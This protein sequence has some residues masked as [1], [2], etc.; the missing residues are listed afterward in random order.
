MLLIATRIFQLFSAPRPLC[1][2]LTGLLLLTTLPLRAEVLPYKDTNLPFTT[3]V[4]DLV[5]RMTLEEKAQQMQIKMAANSRLGIPAWDWWNEAIH[6]IARGG[7]ATMFPQAIGLGAT[8]DPP[9]L[10]LVGEAIGDEARAKF[11]P[12]GARYRGLTM[13]APA[14]NLVRDP[15]WGRA[16]ETYGE[17]PC[18]TTRLA[19]EFCKGLQGDD[20]KYLK[21]VATP[22]H[23]AL[24]SQETGRTSTSFE[25]SETTLRDYYLPAFYACFT[26]A[27]ATS[28]M[29]AH[30]GINKVP[31]TA[32]RWLLTDLLRG[33]WKFEGAVVTDWT[34]IL[35]L[36]QGHHLFKTPEESA[37]GAINAGIDVLSQEPSCEQS[38]LRAV[39]TGLLT[40]EVLDQAVTRN[41]LLRFRLGIFDPPELVAFA[42][43]PASVVGSPAHLNLA[44]QAARESIVLLQNDPALPGYG[45]ERILPLNLRQVRSVALLGPYANVAQLGNYNGDPAAPPITPLAGIRQAF[46]DRIRIRTANWNDE[47]QSLKAAQACDVVLVVLGLNEHLEAE[48][49]DKPNLELPVKQRDF[50][51]RLMEVNPITVV[52]VEG[53]SPV[54]L[55]WI[56]EHVPAVLMLWYP[57]EQG[58]SALAEVLLGQTN[59]SGRLPMTFYRSSSDLPPLD[60]YEISKGR[61]YMYHEKPVP[62]V[63]G[64]GLSYTT[65]EY[66]N[67]KIQPPP[68]ASPPVSPRDRATAVITLEIANTGTRA[69]SEVVQLYVHKTTSP[70]KRPLKQL[71]AF[72]RVTIPVGETRPVRFELPFQDLAFWDVPA[73]KY[74]TESG[75][76]EIMIGASS[77]DLRQRGTL[78]V[79]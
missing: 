31:C 44:L 51:R 63:F 66:R 73:H 40:K 16:Q 15:R 78:E 24:H 74:I 49:M 47:E 61:T 1:R 71:K 4:A 25:V 64:H 35:Y 20:P 56:K 62:F 76:Y 5:G 32:N 77:A 19:V 48:G 42:R 33:E 69:G 41:M 23:F 46:G 70:L 34:A 65:F 10:H 12:N 6:G 3:R 39:N 50:L 14:I 53:G 38:V 52:A 17:D 72:T 7:R 55:T 11:D 58:G 45:F 36:Q 13:W 67:L 9:L 30:S 26:E 75:T 29:A 57:G 2:L 21:T 18:L 68:P 22:K 27:K 43:T 8:W 60:D 59:P 37:A 79:K 54:D 28:V